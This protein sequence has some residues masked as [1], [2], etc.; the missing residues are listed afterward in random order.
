MGVP[1]PRFGERIC[2]VIDLRPGQ[3]APDLA[4]LAAHVREHLADYKAPRELV[5]A[6]IIRAANGK[7]DIKGIRDLAL[8]T[9]GL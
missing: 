3:I 7:V 6:P 9:L 4:T 5:V 2:A 1:D 8:K